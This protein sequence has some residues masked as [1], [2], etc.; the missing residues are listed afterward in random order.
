VRISLNFNTQIFDDEAGLRAILELFFQG[1]ITAME[2]Q[3]R[4]GIST[5]E[6]LSLLGTTFRIAL[7]NRDPRITL[8]AIDRLSP[9]SAMGKTAEAIARL[10][11]NVGTYA[12]LFLASNWLRVAGFAY[13]QYQVYGRGCVLLDCFRCWGVYLSWD[14]LEAE[15]TEST[16]ALTMVLRDRI[17]TYTP[18]AEFIYAIGSLDRPLNVATAGWLAEFTKLKP[19]TEILVGSLLPAISPAECAQHWLAPD[20]VE[21]NMEENSFVLLLCL[22]PSAL[23]CPTCLDHFGVKQRMR[24]MKKRE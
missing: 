21:G 13:R 2:A 15:L 20:N 9:A 4:L 18:D 22:E 7:H 11:A 5:S 16:D 10:S 19:E 6:F 1:H 24:G 23:L 14:V 17:T 12:Q 3:L 8:S